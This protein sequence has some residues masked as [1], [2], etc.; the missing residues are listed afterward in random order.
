M[1]AFREQKNLKKETSKENL[2]KPEKNINFAQKFK[3]YFMKKVI[4]SLCVSVMLLSISCTGGRKETNQSSNENTTVSETSQSS[5][6]STTV[7]ETSKEEQKAE[8]NDEFTRIKIGK[9]YR[10]VIEGAGF[11]SK[12]D[13]DIDDYT[14]SLGLCLEKFPDTSVTIE[15]TYYGDHSTKYVF[16]QKAPAISKMSG[17]RNFKGVFA[18]EWGITTDFEYRTYSQ[19]DVESKG[20]DV[21]PDKYL[22]KK[23]FAFYTDSTFTQVE[24]SRLVSFISSFEFDNTQEVVVNPGLHVGDDLK[25]YPDLNTLR[26]KTNPIGTFYAN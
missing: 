26:E 4:V 11:R 22:E 17:P 8:V 18:G 5:D 12:F 23:S 15:F 14:T 7:P 1:D 19:F 20:I 10:V 16:I 24:D 2:E 6:E 13:N 3:I 25:V 21:T 9:T